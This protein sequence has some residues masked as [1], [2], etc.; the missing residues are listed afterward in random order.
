VKVTNT[1]LPITG[2]I[3]SAVTGTV[4]AT[5]SG[6]WNVGINNTPNVNANITNASVPVSGTVAVSNFPSSSGGSVTVAN[7][8]T[9]PLPVQPVK[10][11]TA[12]YVTLYCYL[13][14]STSFNLSATCIYTAGAPPAPGYLG[15][16]VFPLPGSEVL[17][18][19]DISWFGTCGNIGT[20]Y[21]T[22]GSS[23]AIFLSVNYVGTLY[24]S[25]AVLD[26]TGLVA[27]HS[28][29]FTSGL[30]LAGPGAPN[31]GNLYNTCPE[32]TYSLNLT[33]QGYAV[34]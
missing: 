20:G 22:P 31:V 4:S 13:P 17:V 7:T 6:A 8:P 15:G 12:N 26:A 14:N 10:Q 30:V 19:T 29:H 16:P 27:T 21:V 11:S 3:S 1:P 33:M 5:Q 34:P 18:I 9:N 32:S 28:D 25:S 2:S 23:F 24:L